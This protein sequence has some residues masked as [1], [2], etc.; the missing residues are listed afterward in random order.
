MGRLK[1]QT[2]K[3]VSTDD[4]DAIYERGMKAKAL[5]AGRGASTCFTRVL[6]ISKS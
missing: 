4:I 2:G 3:A 1:R 6:R 5:G